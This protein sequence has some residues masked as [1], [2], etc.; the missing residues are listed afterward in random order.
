MGVTHKARNIPFELEKNYENLIAQRF[1]R[2]GAINRIFWSSADKM[3]AQASEIEETHKAVG[4]SMLKEYSK[5]Y[6]ANKESAS[7]AEAQKMLQ[8]IITLRVQLIGHTVSDISRRQLIK[9][10]HDELAELDPNSSTDFLEGIHR[11]IDGLPTVSPRGFD[12]SHRFAGLKDLISS[13]TNPPQKGI[14]RS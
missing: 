2:Q 7:P 3:K 11:A 8:A 12:I 13:A 6:N 14:A 10:L 9:S 5:F 4:A 1:G